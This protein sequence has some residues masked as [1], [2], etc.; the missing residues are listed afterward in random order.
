[1]T[2]LGMKA[3]ASANT[4]TIMSAYAI[5]AHLGF[6]KLIW[7]HSESKKIDSAR[8]QGAP[9]TAGGPCALHNPLLR[10]GPTL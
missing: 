3:S 2:H 6:V 7:L 8:C 10:H 9:V 1:M 5:Y 4:H